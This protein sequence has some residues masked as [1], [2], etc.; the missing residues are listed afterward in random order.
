MSDTEFGNGAMGRL[1]VLIAEMRSLRAEAERIN[2]GADAI[3]AGMKELREIQLETL[4]L[5][6][7]LFDRFMHVIEAPPSQETLETPHGET[8]P[9][10]PDAATE[11]APD[12]E[13]PA[14][15]KKK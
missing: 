10:A 4:Q 14:A 7:V 15:P 1:A 6:S 2:A 9:D 3:F 5:L 8:S 13:T 11:P 12:A